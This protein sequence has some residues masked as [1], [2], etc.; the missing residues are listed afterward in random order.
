MNRTDQTRQMLDDIAST[1]ATLTKLA[2]DIEPS[3]C[4]DLDHARLTIVADLLND[5]EDKL[6]DICADVN[7]ATE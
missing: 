3:C 2:R 1:L 4:T 7:E 6:A 5:A